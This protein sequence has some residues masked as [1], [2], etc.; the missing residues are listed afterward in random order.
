MD[1]SQKTTYFLPQHEKHLGFHI[2]GKLNENI[3]KFTGNKKLYI[4]TS[5]HIS[6]CI[7]YYIAISN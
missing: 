7:L 6:E 5:K 3:V 4:T 2:R 1:F